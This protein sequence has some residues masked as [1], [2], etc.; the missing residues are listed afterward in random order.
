MDGKFFDAL[1]TRDPETRERAQMA[2]LAAQIALA[3][4]K[5]A[6]FAE[7]LFTSMSKTTPTLDAD[8]IRRLVN[9][10]GSPRVMFLM[11]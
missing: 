6:F 3:K 4:T 9:D 2:A 8:A 1:E 10:L 5:T 7:S 11:H